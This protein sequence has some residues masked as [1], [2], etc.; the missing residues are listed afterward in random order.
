VSCNRLLECIKE[1]QNDIYKVKFLRIYRTRPIWDM[2][3]ERVGPCP[4]VAKRYDN[5]KYSGT[6]ID[7]QI[8]PYFTLDEHFNIIMVGN[9]AKNLRKA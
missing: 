4:E 9:K 5:T 2:V 1:A 8:L 6:H 3:V 7:S